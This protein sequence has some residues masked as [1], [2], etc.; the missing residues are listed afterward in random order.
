MTDLTVY[1]ILGIV[2]PGAL[3]LGIYLRNELINFHENYRHRH[4]HHHNA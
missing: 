2:I 1:I 4:G 3:V